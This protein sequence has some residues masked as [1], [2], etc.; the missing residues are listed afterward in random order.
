M[1]TKRLP[2]RVKVTLRKMSHFAC[3][4]ECRKQWRECTKRSPKGL[5]SRAKSHLWSTCFGGPLCNA[6][7]WTPFLLLCA[8]KSNRQFQTCDLKHYIPKVSKISHF[9]SLSFHKIH[10]FKDS[11]VTKFTISKSCFSQN[12]QFQSLIFHKI[13]NFKVT[14]FTKITFLEYH[15]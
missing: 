15:I 1:P 3:L 4:H 9:Q 12:S 14:F 2:P 8:R 10:I 13:H 11:F 6:L 7:H 5:K